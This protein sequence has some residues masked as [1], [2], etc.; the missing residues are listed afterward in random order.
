MHAGEQ[1]HG[2]FEFSPKRRPLRPRVAKIAGLELQARPPKEFRKAP[3]GRILQSPK[4]RLTRKDQPK[5][6]R[7][8]PERFDPLLIAPVNPLSRPRKNGARRCRKA[9]MN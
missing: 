1:R 3:T 9:S 7:H 4:C 5:T 8:N 6:G 2:Y